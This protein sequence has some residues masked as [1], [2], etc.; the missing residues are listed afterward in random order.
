MN[1]SVFY[2]SNFK[3][4]DFEALED[5]ILTSNDPEA[6]AQKV[7]EE[8]L[9]QVDTDF[10]KKLVSDF[11]GDVLRIVNSKKLLPTGLD[12]E[13]FTENSYRANLLLLRIFILNDE[14]EKAAKLKEYLESQDPDNRDLLKL[15]I[16]FSEAY[17][18]EREQALKAYLK[19]FP[20]SPKQTEELAAIY[21]YQGKNDK[22]LKLYR[23]LRDYHPETHMKAAYGFMS[24]FPHLFSREDLRKER[25]YLKENFPNLSSQVKF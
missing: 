7:Q 12:Q 14:D 11:T 24:C 9:P 8:L 18:R 17:S 16:K 25:N 21:V 2:D 23:D 1:K 22:A 5:R 6:E 20:V 15:Q 4:F 3:A 10:K 19:V 13:D